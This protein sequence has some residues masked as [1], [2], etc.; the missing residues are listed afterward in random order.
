[1]VPG[2]AVT[3]VDPP[4]IPGKTALSSFLEAPGINMQSYCVPFPVAAYL[5][6][7]MREN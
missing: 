6:E 3:R 4:N 5:N 1:M 2:V 7:Q